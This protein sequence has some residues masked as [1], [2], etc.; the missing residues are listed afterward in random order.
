MPKET[1]FDGLI[2]VLPGAEVRIDL[3]KKRQ[4]DKIGPDP[5]RPRLEG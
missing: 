2:T 4:G 3:N 5:K 1:I